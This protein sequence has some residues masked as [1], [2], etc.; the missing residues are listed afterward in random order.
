MVARSVL[1]KTY[2]V[3]DQESKNVFSEVYL[4]KEERM[5]Y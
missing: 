1:K 2:A 3:T 4:Q 5:E